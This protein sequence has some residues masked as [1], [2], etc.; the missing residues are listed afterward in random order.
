MNY[1]MKFVRRKS[2]LTL[3]EVV[4]AVCFLAVTFIP[5]MS[6]FSTNLKVTEKDSSNIIAADLCREK[7]DTAV[8]MGFSSF[9][10]LLNNDI[11]NTTINNSIP[12]AMNLDLR[13]RT[14]NNVV[15]HFTLR[16]T[17]RDGDFSYKPRVYRDNEE[18]PNSPTAYQ[19]A[20]RTFQFGAVTTDHYTNLVRRYKMTVT[21]YDRGI[22]QKRRTANAKLHSYTLLT[23]KA[24][25]KDD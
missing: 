7:L 8:A 5:I 3:L 20:A 10:I 21:W 6:L 19:Q 22:E 18:I 24:N 1:A 16:V 4:T 23:F 25:L 2:A 14:I 12:G 13:D 11:T 15:Y 17:N 9:N